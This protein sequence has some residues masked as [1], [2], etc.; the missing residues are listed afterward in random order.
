MKELML[1]SMQEQPCSMKTILRTQMH[2]ALSVP[3][4]RYISD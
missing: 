4:P 3:Y 1:F 2:F